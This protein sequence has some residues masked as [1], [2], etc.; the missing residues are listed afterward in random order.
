MSWDDEEPAT[1]QQGNWDDEE[2]DDVA[3]DWDAESGGDEEGDE[4]VKAAA[5]AAAVP[6]PKPAKISKNKLAAKIKMREDAERAAKRAAMEKEGPMDEAAQRKAQVRSDT[7]LT[8]GVFAGLDDPD[9]GITLVAP[10]EE[11][12]QAKEEKHAPLELGQHVATGSLRDYSWTKASDYKEFAAELKK[13][14]NEPGTKND[15]KLLLLKELMDGVI[16]NFNLE[17][18]KELSDK[19]AVVYNK[20]RNERQSSNKKKKG[21][22]AKISLGG[23]KAVSRHNDYDDDGGYYDKYDNFGR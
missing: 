15:H 16:S 2:Q 7:M 10:E 20:K 21:G 5:A 12:A 6:K 19:I 8:M 4:K 14:L 9:S 23:G 1:V 18:V 13:K 11:A 22:K 17:Q 3:D